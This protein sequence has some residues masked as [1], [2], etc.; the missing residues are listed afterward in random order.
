MNMEHTNF[1]IQDSILKMYHGINKH[2]VIPEGVME[3]GDEAFEDN[4]F[5]QVLEVPST[6]VK[7]DA[8]LFYGCSCL[9]DIIISPD[10]PYMTKIDNCIYS[11][12]KTTLLLYPPYLKAE[13]FIIPDF[14]KEIGKMAFYRS[15]VKTVIC[16]SGL[17]TIDE[18]AF[19]S[20][21]KL[22]KIYISDT[23]TEIGDEAFFNCESLTRI[24]IPGKVK[25]IKTSVFEN[26]DSLKEVILDG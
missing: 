20:C 7:I 3:I 12:D 5:I 19:F 14:V 1:K 25:I 24:N 11:N 9:K 23:V 17:E 22:E 2:V 21:E 16:N 4:Q 15:S 26:C 6:L 13:K 10:N 18:Q 8:W